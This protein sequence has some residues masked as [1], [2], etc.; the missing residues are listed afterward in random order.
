MRAGLLAFVVTP[1]A[2]VGGWFAAAEKNAVFEDQQYG[3]RIEGPQFG[4][5][6]VQTRVAILGPVSQGFAPNV[7]VVLQPPMSRER[8]SEMS[9]RQ[10]KEMELDVK[11]E[12][13]KAVGGRE[14][15]LWEYSGPM[16]GRDLHF[17]ALAVMGESQTYLTTCTATPKQFEKYEQA[18]RSCL[19]SFQ[20]LD[21][22]KP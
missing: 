2:F 8:F 10:F 20:I 9:R 21:R 12:Q 15:V 22:G 5:G 18:F 11:S 3:F 19:D 13:N 16:Q 14:A 1:L 6:P 17:L 7:N 4:D